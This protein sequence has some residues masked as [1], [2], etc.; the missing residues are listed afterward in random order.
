MR[1]PAERLQGAA[2][3]LRKEAGKAA[4][5]FKGAFCMRATAVY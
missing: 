5:A 2:H 1:A 4:A 3:K